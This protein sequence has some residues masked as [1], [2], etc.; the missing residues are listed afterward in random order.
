MKTFLA[1]AAAFGLMT[2]AALAECG[3]HQKV[4]ASA[5]TDRSMT[6]ASIP[7]NQEIVVAKKKPAESQATVTE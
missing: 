6:T 1:A 4:T 5:E 3:S 7:D 2:S